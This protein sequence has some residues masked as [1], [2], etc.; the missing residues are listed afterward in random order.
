MGIATTRINDRVLAA[1][2]EGGN[3]VPEFEAH[4]GVCNGGVLFLL[5]ALLS[6]GL[7][8]TKDLYK[9]PETHY[10]GLE[11]VLL[12]LAF[13]ALAR[14]KNP[15]QLKQC[16][17]GEIGR[18]IGLDRTPEVKCLREKIK[19]LSGQNH[20]QELNRKLVDHW[21]APNQEEELFLYIDG[22]VRVYFGE[23]AN[24]P[25]KFVSR[26]KLCLN[27]TTEYWVN[28]MQGLP[29]LMVTGELTQK[30]QAAIEGQI[31]PQL[32]KTILLP[33]AKAEPQSNEGL[34][35]EVPAVPV[36]A[37]GAATATEPVAT[38]WPENNGP[39]ATPPVC[40]LIFDR[41]AYDIPFFKRLW[42][43]YQI[44]MLTYRKNV[45]DSW[46]EESFKDM[47]VTVLEQQITM[48]LCEK[49]VTLGGV[50]FREIRRLTDS[51]H[52][53]SIITNNQQITTEQAAGR[54]FGRWSQENFFKYMIADYDFDKMIEYGVQAIDE[55]K[56]VV[57]P[58]YRKLSQQLKKQKD[59]T[60]RLLVK[61]MEMMEKA[62]E[63]PVGQLPKLQLKE[64][65]LI[66]KINA[67]RSQEQEILNQREGVTRKIILKDMPGQ[68]RYD[69]LKPESKML[70]NIIKMICY[71][72]E[73]VIVNLL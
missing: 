1:V 3:A 29:V 19:L 63:V 12:T 53:T 27:A 43:N 39:Q 42:G 7:L 73:T 35:V 57:N 32:Q 65:D 6:Q 64:S 31:I 34:S 59:K 58:Q 37:P 2:G 60:A 45:K 44:A 36:T 38:P 26:Q 61:M 28:D 33:C 70:M 20:A 46:E 72:A 4:D 68:Q 67:S 15:E 16:R 8:K 25:A 30:L 21:Y 56:E 14:I 55:N 11:S 50:Q 23:L 52:Q 62:I 5:P 18:L 69:E 17:P 54:M 48:N 22:H 40:T 24:L 10:Y 71:R 66:E 47:V 51:G 13:M 49:K 41:E 9:I